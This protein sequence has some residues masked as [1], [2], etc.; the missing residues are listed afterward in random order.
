MSIDLRNIPDAVCDFFIVCD[1]QSTTQVK[2]IADNIVRQTEDKLGEKP[3]H[4]EGLQH[5]EWVLLDYVDT[6]A[7][8]FLTPRRKFY[9]LEELWSDA[10]IEEHND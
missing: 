10:V 6:V 1:A 9:Q 8:I 7:H 3:W 4:A 2:A 5:A